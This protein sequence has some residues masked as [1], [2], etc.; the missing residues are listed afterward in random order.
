MPTAWITEANGDAD[1]AGYSA[2][3]GI[4]APA[5]TALGSAT[6]TSNVKLTGSQNLGANTSVNAILLDGAVTLGGA[7][8]LTLANAALL[9]VAAGVS[10]VLAPAAAGIAAATTV[11]LSANSTFITDRRTT[12]AVLATVNE[13][14]GALP[15]VTAGKGTLVLAGAN[16]Y[17]GATTITEGVVNVQNSTSLG[18]AAGATTVLTGAQL[19]VQGSGLSI[20]ENITLNGVGVAFG[21]G[22]DNSGALRMIDGTPGVTETNTLTGNVVLNSTSWVRVDG[23]GANPDRLIFGGAGVVS[24]GGALIK[25]GAGELEMGGSAANTY[26][27]GTTIDEG[28]VR[29]NKSG[30]T[31]A[32]SAQALGVNDNVTVGDNVGGDNA[33]QLIG[34]SSFNL[35]HDQTSNGQIIVNSTGLINLNGQSENLSA[36][37]SPNLTLVVGPTASGDFTT[38]AA[39][40]TVNLRGDVTVNVLAGGTPVAATISGNILLSLATAAQR[41]FT[42]NDSAALDDLIVSANLGET[43]GFAAGIIKA[44]N[45]RMTVTGN[46]TYTGVVNVNA[47]EFNV[48]SATAL[49]STTGGTVLA[50]GAGLLLSNNVTVGAEAIT[51]ITGTGFGGAGVVRSISGVNELD[52][53]FT[54]S[55]GSTVG[56][57]AGGTLT[58]GGVVGGNQTL[59]KLLGGTLVFAGSSANTNTGTTVVSEGTLLLNKGTGAGGVDAIAGQLTV[60]NDAGGPQADVVRLLQD[61]QINDGVLVVVTDSGLLDLNGHNET[62]GNA[63]NLRFFYGLTFSAAVHDGRRDPDAG[64]GRQHRDV[65]HRRRHPLAVHDAGRH[66]HRQARPGRQH[67]DVQPDARRHDRRHHHPGTERCGH[68]HEHRQRRHRDRRQQRRRHDRQGDHRGQHPGPQRQ[69]QRLRRGRR[70]VRRHDRRHQRQLPRH[71]HADAERRHAP[72]RRRRGHTVQQH[73]ADR[74]FHHRRLP[75]ADSQG[76][77]DAD[78]QRHA[79]RHRPRRRHSAKR[80]GE[81]RHGRGHHADAGRQLQRPRHGQRYDHQQRQRRQPDQGRH[82]RPDAEREQHLHRSPPRSAPA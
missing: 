69:Q 79:D 78:H 74:Q 7:F 5:Y 45:G 33:D 71:G 6:A 56:V 36:V 51:G 15:L 66:D 65:Q 42:I 1:L 18:T 50:N 60:S 28:T 53:A 68:D 27:G 64:R 81:H 80:Y 9:V 62:V 3:A 13:T 23:G 40:N 43:S 37:T 67:A 47:G 35:L 72:R 41:T 52:G 20:A 4:A 8:T 22:G 76:Q 77:P 25:A 54:M 48:A 46:N 44:G 19:Q 12:D 82:G 55:G 16:S 26:T 61:N 2:A 14:G 59:T 32:A 10:P 70:A 57:D 58:L 30:G 11:V 34:I 17:T 75:A 21:A 73:F 24:G 38:G 49:G 29:L 39:G 63:E 31:S